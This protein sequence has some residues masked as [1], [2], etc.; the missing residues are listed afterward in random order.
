MLT[1]R[2]CFGLLFG[3]AASTAAPAAV[4][5]DG[6]TVYIY[7]LNL[8]SHGW[9][10]TDFDKDLYTTWDACSRSV[11]ARKAAN[12]RSRTDFE[13]FVIVRT[14]SQPPSGRLTNDRSKFSYR[15]VY[16]PPGR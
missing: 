2:G 8:P 7:N 6:Y 16:V 1:R 10:R 11:Q 3:L 13:A 15:I 9:I 4:K 12:K 14:S 5:A